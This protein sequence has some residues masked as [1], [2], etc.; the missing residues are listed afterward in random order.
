MARL[1]GYLRLSYLPRW[2]SSAFLKTRSPFSSTTDFPRVMLPAWRR[3]SRETL[4]NRSTVSAASAA[5]L[6]QSESSPKRSVASNR[7]TF[8][9][10][11]RRNSAAEMY[12]GKLSRGLPTK[13]RSRPSASSLINWPWPMTTS[14][15]V[16]VNNTL[17]MWHRF[18][19]GHSSSTSRKASISPVASRMPRLRAAAGPAFS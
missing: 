1:L 4:G 18:P 16:V 13:T 12:Q 15:P 5:R 6:N 2:R 8:V 9:N 7:P 10:A 3:I 17:D 19:A 14:T 11:S